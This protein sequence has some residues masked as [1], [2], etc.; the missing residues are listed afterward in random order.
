[1]AAFIL[2][3]GGEEYYQLH[4]RCLTSLFNTVPMERIDLRVGSNQ[5][6]ARST[7]MIE[8][9]VERKLITKHYAHDSNDYKYPV[10]REMFY[11][12]EH[13]IRTKW[14]LWFDD[15]SICKDPN[16]LNILGLLISQH[17]KDNDAHMI[18]TKMVWTTNSKQRKIMEDRAWYKGKPWRQHNGRP[19]PNG[20][21]I[22][23][24][25]GGFWAL[26]HEAMVAA[27]IPDLGTGLTHTGGDWQI[28]EQ[29]Y[30]AG[31]GIKMFNTKKQFITTS[32]TKRRGVTMPTIDKAGAPQRP[33]KQQI[34]AAP[35][36]QI[37]RPP[38][39]RRVQLP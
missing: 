14:V 21:K 11:D 20:N 23:F 4:E 12:R 30:Q 5:L 33:T 13:P 34:L 3:Y 16:W 15:D 38:K 8:K 37:P 39:L 27:D 26:T 7:E 35:V 17:H 22:L 19:S 24:V 36:T 1:M 29:L 18:G 31:Y 10:M 25:S 6:N 9:A 2:F 28:G 32:S